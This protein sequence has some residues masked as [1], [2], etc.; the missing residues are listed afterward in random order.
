MRTTIRMDDDLLRAA[1]RRAGD[2]GRTLTA[3]IEQAVR[4]ELRRTDAEPEREPY[5][6]RPFAGD[7]VREGVG[8][9]D[10]AALRDLMDAG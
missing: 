4:A 5:V 9:D 10:N 2:Q 8:L 6:V 7:G 1:K 3:F